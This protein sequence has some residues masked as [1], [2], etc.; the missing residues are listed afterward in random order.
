MW[1]YGSM[2]M[3][4]Y[5][6]LLVDTPVYGMS[7]VMSVIEIHG[8]TMRYAMLQSVWPVPNCDVIA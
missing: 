6:E 8:P 3:S 1:L 4:V 5:V 2:T 7:R